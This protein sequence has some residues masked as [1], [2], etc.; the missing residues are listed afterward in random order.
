MAEGHSVSRPPFLDGTDYTYWK[1]QIHVFLR[2][3]DYELWKIISKGPYELP[4]DEDTWTREQICKG[5]LNWS[6]LNMM[7]C[8]VHPK[9]YSR[10]STC[11]SAKEM[12]DKLEL[13]YEGTSEVRETKASMLVSKYDMFKM[14]NEETIS[15][16]FSR[17]MIII[18]GLKGL[19]KEYSESDLVKNILQSLP[20]SWHTKA[21]LIEDS[22][23]LSTMKLDELI[24]SLMT[25]EINLKRKESE[26]N[27]RKS[28]ALKASNKASSSSK[29]DIQQENDENETS[30]ESEN[31]E[32]A[33]LTRQF[34]K[35]LKFKKKGPGNFKTL[36]KRDFSNKFDINKKTDMIV[37]Y[38]C[39][40]Q[41]HMR[42]ECPELKRKLKKTSLHTRNLGP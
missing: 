28:I 7:Q 32:M 11:K 36:P 14:K 27:P 42:G 24:G 40:R 15:D 23:D 4:A 20:S 38:E 22:K 8:A 35:F 9:E 16:M 34:K 29:K 21:T 5:T 19:K 13:I 12:W 31:D 1:N 30:S 33:M 18:N 2:A 3:H 10:V 6:T 39:K 41:G 25:Y 37:C 17:F 26:V